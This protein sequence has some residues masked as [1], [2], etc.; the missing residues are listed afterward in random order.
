MAVL[1]GAFDCDVPLEAL[2]DP[3]EVADGVVEAAAPPTGEPF[4]PRGGILSR[5]L[6]FFVTVS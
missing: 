5:T 1:A 4:G 6:D 2:A 3:L